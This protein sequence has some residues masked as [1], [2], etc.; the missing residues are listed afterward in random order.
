MSKPRTWDDRVNMVRG[1]NLVDACGKDDVATLLQYID[2]IEQALDDAD[3][4]DT[5][6]TEGWRHAILGEDA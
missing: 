4:E 2:T 6:G 3:A 5:F 1:K